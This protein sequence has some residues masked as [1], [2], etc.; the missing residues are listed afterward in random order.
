MR[1]CPELSQVQIS[2]GQLQVRQQ[3]VLTSAGDTYLSPWGKYATELSALKFTAPPTSSNRVPEATAGAF[4]Q[5]TSTEDIQ[6][7][8]PQSRPS[9]RITGDVSCVPKFW[10][11]IVTSV[12]PCAEISSGLT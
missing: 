6:I 9:M 5:S 4:L 7:D 8:A 2:S 10:P 3:A 1:W 12:V 11:K